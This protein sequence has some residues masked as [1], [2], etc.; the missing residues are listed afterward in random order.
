MEGPGGYQFF[1]RTLQM[2]NRNHKTKAFEKPWLLR[3]FDQIR[4]YEVTH[5]E[6]MDIRQ[7]FPK[8]LYDIKIE[9]TTFSLADYKKILCENHDEIVLAKE[10]QQK[11]FD[12]EYQR[13]VESGQV[14]FSAESES[15]EKNEDEL[16]LLDAETAVESVIS[17]SVWKVLAK[18]GQKVKA[19]DV[20]MIVESMKME[21]SITASSSGTISRILKKEGSTVTAGQALFVIKEENS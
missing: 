20:V 19:G 15:V 17:C 3:F 1:G 2:W 13:W 18:E 9:Q 12:E 4:F 5:D 10:R 11:A 14:N 16:V 6:L 21:I 7:K 8:G